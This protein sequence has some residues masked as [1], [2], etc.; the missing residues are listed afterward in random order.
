LIIPATTIITKA[1][2]LIDI[3]YCDRVTKK[4]AALTKLAKVAP[5]PKVTNTAGNAQ[6]INVDVEANNEK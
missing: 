3:L 4:G 1:K 2:R 6:Q 5:A